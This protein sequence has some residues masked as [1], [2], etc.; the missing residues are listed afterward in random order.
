MQQRR[1]GP[2]GVSAIGLGCMGMTPIYG[3]PDEAE[4]IA[5][6]HRAVELGVTLIDTADAYAAGRNEELVG[7]ALQGRCDKVV[8]ATKFGN[9]RKPDGGQDVD[10]RPAYVQEACELSLKRLGVETIDL[11]YQH[12]VDPKVPI[13]ETV[14]AM[15][16]LVDQG[17]V[18]HLGLS[19]AAAGTLRR[20]H[21]T[22]PITALQTEYSLWSR[23]VEAEILPA[24]RE[25]G[26]GF[27]AYSP[28]GRG[29][30]S[31]RITSLDALS[32][33]DRRRDHPRFHADNLKRNV[34]LLG[35]LRAI[36][37]ARNCTPAQVA[38]AWLLAQGDDIVPIP[39][40]KRRTFLEE[41]AGA[42]E[43]RLN[44]VERA[45][46]AEVFPPGVT[47]GDRYPAGQMKRIGI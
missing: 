15:A 33:N 19:E 37:A 1:L 46:L 13:E 3:E 47:A 24:C 27:V 17:K 43:I 22:H 6:V 2:L 23:D 21:A 35:V 12:R 30:L 14:G 38:L 11:Y 44:D 39:G 10:G 20:A 45:R 9:I 4:C 31:G 16:R 18:R 8:L 41:N 26:I 34:G 5:T 7:R 40:T 42:L 28:L 29:F 36:A 32:E 25:L